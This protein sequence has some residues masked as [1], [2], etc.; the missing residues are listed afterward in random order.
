MQTKSSLAL[1]SLLFLALLASAHSRHLW[2]G[3]SSYFLHGLKKNDRLAVLQAAK[4]ANLKVIRIF[5][6]STFYHSHNTDSDAISD[7]ES[8]PG[9]YN[10][11]ILGQIDDLM[12]DAKNYGIKLIIAMHDRYGLTHSQE[13]YVK[14]Y[15][16]K[17]N[18][19]SGS[20]N[21]A[22]KFYTDK[23]AIADFDRR[24]VHILTHRNPHFNN[25]QWAELSEVVF[26]F[27]AQNEAMGH[28]GLVNLN[29]Q[30]DRAKVLK[31]YV[32]NGVLV[33][34]G[35]GIDFDTSSKVQYFQCPYINVISLHTYDYDANKIGQKVAEAKNLA[36][37]YG[38]R[39]IVE[40]FGAKGG[41]KQN[42]LNRQIAA[43][44]NQGVPW[45]V[46]QILRPG[47]GAKDYEIGTNEE[48]WWNS[49]LP[50]GKETAGTKHGWDWPEIWS[51]DNDG[52]HGSPW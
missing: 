15:G 10:D 6:T 44:K 26:S 47:A 11:K 50:R 9:S 21:D 5:I 52:S 25:R 29:W 27:E 34:T 30:C 12:A 33:S 36:F 20:P 48:S 13:A 31:Q 2:G 14:K 46:W 42:V 23:N 3:A 8:W 38:K 39:I 37:K 45:I 18:G 43:I 16:I 19:E 7:L 41:D 17:T 49:I 35:G 40:E 4:D 51:G 1:F 22:S 32:K 24:L 28:M